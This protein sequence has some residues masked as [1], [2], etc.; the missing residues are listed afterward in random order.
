M[1]DSVCLWPYIRVAKDNKLQPNW[2]IID[3][4]IFDYEILFVMEGEVLFRIEDT[5]R[6][7]LPG[8]F[9]LFKPRQRHSVI[10]VGDMPLRQPHMHFDL[11]EQPNSEE[12]K[13]SFKTMEK[14]TKEE[15]LLFR[16]DLT[17]GS[18][19]NLPNHIRIG[20]PSILEQL[21]HDIITEYSMKLPYYEMRMKGL[22]VQFW[23]ELLR[24]T[25]WDAKHYVAPNLEALQQV[26]H[27]LGQHLTEEVSLDT[28]SKL[29]NMSKSHLIR[30]FRLSFGMSPIQYQQSVRMERAKELVQFT[31]KPFTEIADKFGYQSIHS[32]SRAFRN[33]EGVPPSN[34]RKRWQRRDV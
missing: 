19:W 34:Y 3:R 20:N 7:G 27:Y 25:C 4:V 33:M 30:L 10:V 31:D 12:V 29:V 2:T 32:F 5:E 21:L 24:E 22:F 23:A 18:P 8:D 28:L 17:S 26:R 9:I 14:F 1:M 13:V 11:I 16:D 15:M 6:R